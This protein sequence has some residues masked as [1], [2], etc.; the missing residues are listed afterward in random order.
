MFPE[1]AE[2]T[3]VPPPPLQEVLCSPT[4]LPGRAMGAV[5]SSS[6]AHVHAN[7]FLD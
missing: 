7:F 3:A 2:M 4:P 6:G 1:R 5:S